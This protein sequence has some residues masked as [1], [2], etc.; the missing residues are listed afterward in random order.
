MCYIINIYIRVLQITMQLT[1]EIQQHNNT[2]TQQHNNTTT[3]QTHDIFITS[4]RSIKMH[5]FI[6]STI[7]NYIQ[8]YSTIFN[9]INLNIEYKTAPRIKHKNVKI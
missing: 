9:Y 3:Q 2:T 7:F 5:S 1:D 6:K 4:T 8:L